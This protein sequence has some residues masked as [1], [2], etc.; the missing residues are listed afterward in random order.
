MYDHTS[1]SR[2]LAR[3]SPGTPAFELGR[4]SG[5]SELL[6]LPE[7]G[8]LCQNRRHGGTR[9]SEE[10]VSLRV[11]RVVCRA[12]VMVLGAKEEDVVYRALESRY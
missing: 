9:R 7:E 11:L 5:L 8:A 10:P 4:F 2:Y 1:T 6:G 3:A 12:T